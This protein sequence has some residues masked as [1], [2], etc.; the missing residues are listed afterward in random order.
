[1]KLE[2]SVETGETGEGRK[3]VKYWVS[4]V[5]KIHVIDSSFLI[6]GSKS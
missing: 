6:I 5:P 3:F 1:M 4:L 2:R